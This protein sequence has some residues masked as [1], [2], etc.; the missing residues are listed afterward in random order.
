MTPH[1][2]APQKILCL[3]TFFHFSD[4]AWKHSTWLRDLPKMVALPNHPIFH[5]FCAE[6]HCFWGS[7][8]KTPPFIWVHFVL[9]VCLLISMLIGIS[10]R[11]NAVSARIRHPNF[12]RNW[13][14]M[15]NSRFTIGVNRY[16][17]PLTMNSDTS[18]QILSDKVF[19]WGSPGFLMFFLLNTQGLD[20]GC[21][22]RA[23]MWLAHQRLVL[24]TMRI[25]CY[26]RCD[27]TV[28]Q[29]I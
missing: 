10:K 3:L 18:M 12:T 24:P 28:L 8:F 7:L 13:W 20:P 17:S 19:H 16:G 14:S 22:Q 11:S 25:L 1:Q 4:V 29:L 5:H 27:Y 21:L 9:P 15:F 2:A 6:T 23:P 26:A